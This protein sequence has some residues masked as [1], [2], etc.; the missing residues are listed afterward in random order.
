MDAAAHDL[1]HFLGDYARHRVDGLGD[2]GE[3]GGK[4]W[5][6]DAVAGAEQHDHSL[7]DDAPEAEEHG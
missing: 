5:N 2:D 4:V 1:A 6:R 7:P 3:S